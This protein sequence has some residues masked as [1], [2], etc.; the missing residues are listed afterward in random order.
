M[1]HQWH[2]SQLMRLPWGKWDYHPQYATRRRLPHD[3][4]G[5]LV[6]NVR[7]D[8]LGALLELEASGALRV[9]QGPHAEWVAWNILL[10]KLDMDFLVSH[11]Q[12]LLERLTLYERLVL[13]LSQTV[14][15]QTQIE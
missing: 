6:L 2:T 10:L 7:R 11:R 4:T 1:I 5:F 14:D 12:R 9:R 15:K 13:H 3:H 8:N